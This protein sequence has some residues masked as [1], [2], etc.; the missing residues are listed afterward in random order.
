[1]SGK[2][3]KTILPSL[4]NPVDWTFKMSDTLQEALKSAD[5]DFVKRT[6]SAFEAK[7]TRAANFLIE[8]LRK[9]NDNKFI[10]NDIDENYVSSLLSN[11]QKAKDSLEELHVRC[12]AVFFHKD[13][14]GEEYLGNIDNEYFGTL[15]K[16]HKEAVKLFN[17]YSSQL[18]AF[19]ETTK[20]KE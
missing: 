9:D 1:M 19:H 18:N 8:E 13:G 5:V 7:L 20:Y 11:L 10:L 6:R 14:P 2:H 15:D 17:S 12:I 4:F 16:T 3:F